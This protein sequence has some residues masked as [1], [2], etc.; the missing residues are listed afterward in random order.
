MSKYLQ[1]KQRSREVV[2][3]D[4][5]DNKCRT[6]LKP[7]GG[8]LRAGASLRGITSVKKGQ[9]EL[10]LE[11]PGSSSSSLKPRPGGPRQTPANAAATTA[12]RAWE[13]GLPTTAACSAARLAGVVNISDPVRLHSHAVQPFESR[14]S[15]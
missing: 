2:R 12:T 8:C 3:H 15:V 7:G 5:D 1:R 11:A 6:E 14:P 9:V 13:H 10:T 4:H